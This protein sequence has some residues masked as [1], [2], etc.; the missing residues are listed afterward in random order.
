MRNL[1]KYNELIKESSGD[2]DEGKISNLKD[3]IENFYNRSGI[4][5]EISSFDYDLKINIDINKTEK[6]SNL[7][8]IFDI[9]NRVNLDLLGEYESEFDIIT[10]KNRSYISFNFYY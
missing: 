6:I 4:E 1:K 2:Y 8:K 10:N 3:L 5:V 9:T 7:L